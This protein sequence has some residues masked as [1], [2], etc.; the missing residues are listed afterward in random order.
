MTKN[1]QIFRTDLEKNKAIVKK[2]L[3]CNKLGATC[4]SFLR[5]VLI[6]QRFIQ[7]FLKM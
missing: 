2:V 1:D 4:F 7:N 6:N 5:R 3:E